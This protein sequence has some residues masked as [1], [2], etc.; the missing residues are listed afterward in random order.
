MSPIQVILNLYPHY[1]TY[2]SL[3][4]HTW[5]DCVHSIFWLTNRN[6]D[7]QYPITYEGLY[8]KY[9]NTP[10]QDLQEIIQGMVLILQ[11]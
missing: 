2:K 1:T 4:I 7:W 9:R 11:L 6:K 8:D 10:I 3:Q 5:E